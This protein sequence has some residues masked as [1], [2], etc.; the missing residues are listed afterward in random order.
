ME[1]LVART[2][3]AQLGGELEHLGLQL[4]ELLGVVLGAL[5]LELG[6]LLHHD[7]KVTL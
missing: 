1:R 6:Q 2:E 7:T 4:G 5:L 3:V